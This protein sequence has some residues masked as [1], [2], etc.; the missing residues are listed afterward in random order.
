MNNLQIRDDTGQIVFQ[1]Q[2]RKGHEWMTVTLALRHHPASETHPR[3]R[4]ALALSVVSSFGNFGHEWYNIRSGGP[5]GAREHAFSFLA[6][7]ARDNFLDRIVDNDRQE[8]DFEAT[9]TAFREA[10]AEALSS[11]DPQ[12]EAAQ[13]MREAILEIE[14]CIEDMDDSHCDEHKVA[15]LLGSAGL[16]DILP[17]TAHEIAVH[18]PSRRR[19]QAEGFLDRLWKPYLDSLISKDLPAP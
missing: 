15:L 4:L 9:V 18:G 7:M 12:G 1:H 6:N 3:G 14:E 17:Y 5:E 19:R 10:A 8:P 11:L 13:S 16:W 2:V